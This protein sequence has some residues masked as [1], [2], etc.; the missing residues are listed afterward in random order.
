MSHACL[1]SCEFLHHIRSS[2]AFHRPFR[3]SDYAL[4]ERLGSI[5]T[6]RTTKRLTENTFEWLFAFPIYPINN[7]FESDRE[8]ALTIVSRS[9]SHRVVITFFSRPFKNYHVSLVT[10]KLC[11][12]NHDKSRVS[13]RAVYWQ[14]ENL[15]SRHLEP[16][17]CLCS[18]LKISARSSCDLRH[19][20]RV[21][22]VLAT[23]NPFHRSSA[24]T[25]RAHGAS[26][27]SQYRDELSS[28]WMDISS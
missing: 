19:C 20:A 12:I 6:D 4:T 17:S 14:E 13:P 2:L 7:S 22:S 26:C 18:S 9:P 23:V 5:P 11:P 25:T 21:F 28:W 10:N 27:A 24:L 15:E 16:R 3:V 1:S 8:I